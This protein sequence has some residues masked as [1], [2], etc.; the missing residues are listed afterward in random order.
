MVRRPTHG[1]FTLIELLVVIAIIAVLLALLLPS[2]SAAR[3]RGRIVACT[4]TTRQ[5]MVLILSY[6][7]DCDSLGLTNYA[8]NCPYYGQ[9]FPEWNPATGEHVKYDNGSHVW[10]EGRSLAINWRPRL[11]A[12]G[13]GPD[14]ALGCSYQDY[15][16][17]TFRS[18]FNV[19]GPDATNARRAPAFNWFGP[20]IANIG[21][22]SDYTHANLRN[23][24]GTG[25]CDMTSGNPPNGLKL[26]RWYYRGPILACPKV[27][28]RNDSAGLKYFAPAHMPDFVCK[29]W[30]VQPPTSENVGFSDGSV[31]HF[32]DRLARPYDPRTRQ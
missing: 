16:G 2:L 22:A 15:T 30:N 5:A 14:T 10:S 8:I 28:I 24:T 4:N 12:A 7:A 29:E 11:V 31:F 1:V 9:G 32:E 25:W 17:R 27:W 26:V 6:N 23:N 18:S 19:Y 20:G 13:F 3:R 21:E